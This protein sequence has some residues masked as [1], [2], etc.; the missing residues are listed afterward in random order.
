MGGGVSSKH[1]KIVGFEFRR[2]I[3]NPKNQ[4][5]KINFKTDFPNSDRISF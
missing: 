4:V 3:L 2:K 1:T 5:F